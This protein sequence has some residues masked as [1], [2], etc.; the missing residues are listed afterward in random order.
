MVA[1]SET[2]EAAARQLL[3]REAKAM[4]G[5]VLAPVALGLA[6]IGCGIAQAW[7][8]ARLLAALLGR[9]EAGWTELAAVALLA[10]AIAAL[11]LAQERAQLAAGAAARARLRRQVFARL[12]DGGTE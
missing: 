9:G 5:R 6:S 1:S 3:Q 2:P 12:L 10:L 8:L 7:L 4:R 11:S